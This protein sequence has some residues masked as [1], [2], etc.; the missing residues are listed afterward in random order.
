MSKWHSINRMCVYKSSIFRWYGAVSSPELNSVY[1]PMAVLKYLTFSVNLSPVFTLD[2]LIFSCILPSIGFDSF[3]ISLSEFFDIP[4]SFL[5]LAYI[6]L[7]FSWR[8]YLSIVQISFPS[9]WKHTFWLLWLRFQVVF[10]TVFQISIVL[11][12]TFVC[13]YCRCSP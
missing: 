2:F 6:R 7:L 4:I 10:L 8:F 12:V 5:F 1:F 11:Q 13:L 3:H 9:L